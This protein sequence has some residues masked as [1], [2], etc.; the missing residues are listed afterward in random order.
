M[1][2]RT[3]TTATVGINYVSGVQGM[4]KQLIDKAASA[5]TKRSR[6]ELWPGRD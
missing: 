5:V 4:F 1:K 6:R 3:D 2:K